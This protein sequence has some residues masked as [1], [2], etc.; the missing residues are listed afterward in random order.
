[1]AQQHTTIRQLHRTR[2]TEA[3][4]HGELEIASDLAD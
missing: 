2:P 3:T 1:V 4:E